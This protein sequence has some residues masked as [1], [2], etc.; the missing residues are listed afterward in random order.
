VVIAALVTAEISYLFGL[1][2]LTLG[3]DYFGIATLGFTIIVKVLLDNNADVNMKNEHGNTA[4]IIASETEDSS[5]V[6]ILLKSKADIHVKNTHGDTA[7]SIARKL[8]H[9]TMVSLFNQYLLV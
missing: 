8:E 9:T 7:L 1:P 3:S 5:I 6:K 2:V 4:L